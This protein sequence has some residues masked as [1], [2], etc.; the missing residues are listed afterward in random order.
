MRRLLAS[1]DQRWID[2]ASANVCRFVQEFLREQRRSVGVEA[3]LAWQ[4]HFPGEINLLELIRQQSLELDVYLPV[5]RSDLT[6]GFYQVGSD[7]PAG[8][9]PGYGGILE[10]VPGRDRVF[11]L[12]GTSR[13]VALVPGLAFDHNGNRLGR[14][15][16]FYD[17]FLQE[18]GSTG[19]TAVGLCWG[20]QV[21]DGI[22]VEEHD[23]GVDFLCHERGIVSIQGS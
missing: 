13:A 22:P 6:M 19:L 8:G 15:G 21:T 16:G 5:V 7:W 9:K 11:E 20:I 2:A 18:A 1:L 12:S 10:P 23:C 3:L 17:R 14:G 4:P